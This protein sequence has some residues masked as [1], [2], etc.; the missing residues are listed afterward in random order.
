MWC[1]FIAYMQIILSQVT[2]QIGWSPHLNADNINLSSMIDGYGLEET[3]KLNLI[4]SPE[5][6]KTYFVP[7]KTGWWWWGPGQRTGNEAML[8]Q[9]AETH[10]WLKRGNRLLAVLRH[11]T[12]VSTDVHS[13]W[14]N[15]SIETV[16]PHP[17]G[18]SL[19]NLFW[20]SWWYSRP[21]LIDIQDHCTWV[22][23]K[24]DQV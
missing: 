12:Y 15:T 17:K 21:L 23:V 22:Q 4:A 19:N 24:H 8:S 16:C 1:A 3:V 13:W 9:Q 6:I 5:M 11:V 14:V 10:S 2:C 20:S 7:E 18:E